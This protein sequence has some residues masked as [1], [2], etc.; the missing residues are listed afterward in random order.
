[1]SKFH[2]CISIRRIVLVSLLQDDECD[3]NAD[4]EI[5]ILN[6]RD[7]KGFAVRWVNAEI[8]NS[9]QAINCQIS[10]VILC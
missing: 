9:L 1:M 6:G 4:C 3:P 10:C 2:F 5:H 8:G 7:K